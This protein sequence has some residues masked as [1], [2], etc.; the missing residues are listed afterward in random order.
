MCKAGGQEMNKFLQDNSF[1]AGPDGVGNR[2]G[3]KHFMKN[4]LLCTALVLLIGQAAFATPEL[5]LKTGTTTMVVPGSGN[6]VSFSSP[7][8]GGW[9]IVIIG[10]SRSPMVGLGTPVFTNTVRMICNGG[11]CATNSLDVWLSDTGFTT[12]NPPFVNIYGGILI[13]AGTTSQVAWVGPG[14]T[15]FQSN[16]ADG[17]PTVTGGALISAVGPFTGPGTVGD[18][19]LGGPPAGPSPYSLTIE[20]IFNANGQAV[21]FYP[22]AFVGVPEPSTVMLLGIGL[23]VLLACGKSK[24]CV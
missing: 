16:G 14:N 4:L 12:L 24:S 1:G 5:F 13:G 3:R 11:P 22:F 23:G 20:D 17:P 15:P 10:G 7:N 8:F 6:S 21:S 9:D 18:E 19:K 2:K